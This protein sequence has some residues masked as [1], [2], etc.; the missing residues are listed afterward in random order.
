MFRPDQMGVYIHWPFCAAKC[1]YCDFNSHVR[2]DFD[3]EVWAQAYIKALEHYSELIPEKQVVSIFFGGGTPSLMK[4]ET[5]GSIIDT[6]QKNWRISND[7]EV[8]LE[9]NPTSVEINKFK[10]FYDVGVNRVSLGV[11]AFNDAELKFLGREHSVDEALRAI[12]IAGQVF[13]RYSFDLI[14]ARPNQT[15]EQWEEELKR[16]ADYARGHLS[17]YQLTIERNTPFYM[18]HSRG[19]FKIPDDVQGADFYQVTQD[20]LEGAGLPAYEVSNHAAA[21]Q[22]CRHNLLYWHMA[23]YIGVGAG[24]HGR[25]MNGAEKFAS[26]DH[27]APDVWLKRVQEQGHGAHPFEKL[28]AEDRFIEGL[29]M[30]LRLRDGISMVELE[31]RT[32]LSL[33]DVVDLQKL[34]TVINEGWVIKTD[35]TLYLTREGLLRLNALIPFIVAE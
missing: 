4:S 11:Q 19:E 18:R 24:A 12:E 28:T 13:D 34:D 15:L 35:E 31:K 29:F 20:I 16:A 8:T 6:I 7:L 10:G 25:F 23:D 33:S 30:G 22:E 17:L 3:Q 27:S 2:G 1:P 14:Y 5:V 26:R 9:A 32:G 21:G